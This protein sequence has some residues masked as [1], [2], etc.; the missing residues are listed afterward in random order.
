[1]WSNN[2]LSRIIDASEHIL[3]AGTEKRYSICGISCTNSQKRRVQM[4][5]K[6]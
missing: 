2:L 5:F 1:M 4:S 3:R 6:R